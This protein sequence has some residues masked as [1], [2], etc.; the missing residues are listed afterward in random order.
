MGI[1]AVVFA[2]GGGKYYLGHA[3]I[4]GDARLGGQSAH[5]VKRQAKH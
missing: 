1:G 2:L 3:L 5:E 4:I